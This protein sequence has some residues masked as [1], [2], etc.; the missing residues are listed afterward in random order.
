M[1][2]DDYDGQ[3]MTTQTTQRSISTEGNQLF[4][5]R[6]VEFRHLP[7]VEPSSPRY[8]NGIRVYGGHACATLQLCAIGP[9]NDR[10]NGKPRRMIATATY[11]DKAE[12]RALIEKL[13]E[14]EATL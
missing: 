9:I 6:R 12:V 4:C 11:L 13:Q 1:T 2:T 3:R 10:G 7:D 8:C 14:I 5:T